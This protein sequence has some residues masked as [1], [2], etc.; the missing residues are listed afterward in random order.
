MRSAWILGLCAVGA[1]SGC[2]TEDDRAFGDDRGRTSRKGQPADPVPR[3]AEVDPPAAGTQGAEAR[4]VPTSA[5]GQEDPRDAGG[6]RPPEA[7]GKAHDRNESSNENQQNKALTP[8]ADNDR[9][10]RLKHSDDGIR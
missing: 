7:P 5:G 8:G 3:A 4:M 1:L 9:K 2:R 10:P 6:P